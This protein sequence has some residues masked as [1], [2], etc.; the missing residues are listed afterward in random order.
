[1]LKFIQILYFTIID[2]KEFFRDMK[3][4]LKLGINTAMY[5]YFFKKTLS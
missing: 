4:G 5:I 1:M 3:K 2:C